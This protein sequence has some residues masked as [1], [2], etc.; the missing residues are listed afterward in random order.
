MSGAAPS[1]GGWPPHDVPSAAELL[2]AVAGFLRDEVEAGTEGRLRFHARVA[3]NTLDIV[4]RELELG[5]AQAAAHAE[6]L[7]GLGVGSEAELAEAI[8]GGAFDDRL[9]EVTAVVRA[10]VADKL[11]VAHPGYDGDATGAP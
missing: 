4:R 3:A 6:R 5:P 2:E 7:A 8:R 1:G 11:A 9:D 10:T